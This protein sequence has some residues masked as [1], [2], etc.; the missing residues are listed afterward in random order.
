MT[1]YH[2]AIKAQLTFSQFPKPL[3]PSPPCTTRTPNPGRQ[4]DYL[5]GIQRRMPRKPILNSNHEC[6]FVPKKVN[7]LVCPI[8][9]F[10][11]QS[12][13]EVV[14]ELAQN[15]THFAVCQAR[16]VPRALELKVIKEDTRILNNR[17]SLLPQTVSRAQT[18][19]L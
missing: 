4:S 11:T 9:A 1:M 19:W 15:Q 16:Q 2:F 18:E 12:Q 6:R 14:Q 17:N 5:S 7:F 3:T 8:G 13:V 10:G